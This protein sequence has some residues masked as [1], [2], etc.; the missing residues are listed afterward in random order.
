MKELSYDD[1]SREKNWSSGHLAQ[2]HTCQ[3]SS[4]LSDNH[5]SA[6]FHCDAAASHLD[7]K[8]ALTAL[9]KGQH[10]VAWALHPGWQ[11]ALLL[12]KAMAQP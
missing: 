2:N 3:A 12:Q 6:S 8:L 11:Q 7:S 4:L 9:G 1:K 5:N 10:A